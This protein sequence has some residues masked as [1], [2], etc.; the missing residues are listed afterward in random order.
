M[1]S[2]KSARDF[3]SVGG[4]SR[5]VWA[6]PLERDDQVIGAVAVL[7]DAAVLESQEWSLW[8]RSAVLRIRTGCACGT[9]LPS[10]KPSAGSRNWLPRGPAVSP[11]DGVRGFV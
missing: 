6:V 7:L 8:R 5:L 2:R 9:A 10:R 11:R 4:L 3:R 1:R